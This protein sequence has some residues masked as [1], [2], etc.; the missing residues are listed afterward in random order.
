MDLQTGSNDLPAACRMPI[1]PQTLI[2][3]I[4]VIKRKE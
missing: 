2:H 3:V 4:V 1:I